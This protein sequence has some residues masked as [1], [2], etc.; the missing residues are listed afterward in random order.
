MASGPPKPYF[1]IK[2]KAIKVPVLP[3]PALQWMAIAPSVESNILKNLFMTDLGGI[4]PSG[5]YKS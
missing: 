2:Y 4:L 1:F 5:K 3:K